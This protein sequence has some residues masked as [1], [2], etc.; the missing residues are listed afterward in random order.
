M[1]FERKKKQ[2]KSRIDTSMG[3]ILVE[4]SGGLVGVNMNFLARCSLRGILLKL[5]CMFYG[6]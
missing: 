4:G 1:I 3:G 2:K 6:L 5:L